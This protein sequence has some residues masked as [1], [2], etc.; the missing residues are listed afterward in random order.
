[1]KLGCCYYPE[2]WP[3]DLW[4]EDARRM[5]AMGLQLVRIGEF[6]WSRIEP[7]PGR[8]DWA[9]LDR[10]IDTLAGAGLEIILGTPTA[11]PPKWLVDSMPDMVAI[12]E[13]GRPRG[14]GSRRHYCFSH[15]GYRAECRRIVTALA[16]RYGTHPAIVMWQTDNEYGCHDTVLSFSEAAAAAFRGWLEARYG[17]PA[18][19]NAAWGNVFWSM[20]YRSFA[21]VDPPHLTVTEANPAHWLDYRRFASDEVA[22]FNREQVEILRARSAGRDITH[23]FMGFFTEFDHHDVGR[24]ID[25]ATWDSYPLGF[26][27]QF[28]FSPDEKRAYL[29]QGHPDIAAF[30]H[31]LYRG[32]SK[33]RWGVMEQQ[34]GPVN[35]ARFNPAPLPG[36]VALWTLEAAAH[37]AE[38]TS[39]FR[40]RQAPFAQEQMH[41]GLLR[42][43]S[44]EAEAAP[45]VRAAAAALAEIG[46]QQTAP[47]QVAL[48]FSYEAAWTI[49]I[50]PQG[51]SFRY[52]ELVFECYCAL[53]QRGLDVDIV[54]P[55]A[56]LADHAMVVVPSL[57]IL[58]EGFADRLAALDCPVLLGPRSGSKTAS[59]AIPG[60]LA[61][62]DLARLVPIT[63][64]RVESLRDG[65]SESGGEGE[66]GWAV[67]RWR[68]DVTSDLAPELADAAGRGVLYGKGNIRY[69]AIW[70]DRALLRLLVER[71]AQEAGLPLIDL[72]EG[73]RVRRSASHA[74][75]FNYAAEPVFVPHLGITLAPASWHVEAL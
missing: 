16:E 20:E 22:S 26:L 39:Y 64:T 14:F 13:Q 51:R 2:H 42:P 3:E 32:C 7:E 62:G 52:L 19:L 50:Q 69:C 40:W 4:A 72:P 24:D 59:F 21:E 65:V 70:P 56:D 8:F 68:E 6:A 43:D 61:P 27:E 63:V 31:D 9:W 74:F 28:W 15:R 29:R 33:G 55:G 57:P 46:P 34:P 48:V 23:N 25:V 38:F 18:A 44:S 75:T 49:G 35:W 36:M 17:T 71:M 58:P 47:A 60:R 66:D 12:D 67:T 30:H 41:A 10:A 54:A 45:E 53:R 1:M 11:T 73:I 5:A 37:G